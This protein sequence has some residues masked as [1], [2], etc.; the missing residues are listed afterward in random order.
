[1]SSPDAQAQDPMAMIAILAQ[2]IADIRVTKASAPTP[3]QPVI[4]ANERGS[5]TC[6]VSPT[7][8]PTALEQ[9]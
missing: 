9:S 8:G 7:I 6:M 3:V 4:D 1:M 2:V 5:S